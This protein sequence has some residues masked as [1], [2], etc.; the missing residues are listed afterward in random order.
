MISVKSESNKCCGCGLCSM[1]CPNHAISMKS[2]NEGFL[3]PFIQKE[4]CID[5]GLCLEYCV[6]SEKYVQIYGNNSSNIYIARIKD[7][8]ILMKSASGGMFSLLS[9]AVLKMNGCIYGAV[10]DEQQKVIH[11][12]AD[13]A[14]DRN[15][16]RGSKY[17]QSDICEMYKYITDD[18]ENGNYVLFTGTPCEVGAV[19]AFVKQKKINNEHLFLCDLICHGVCSPMIWDKYIGYVKKEIGPIKQINMRDKLYG[20]GY[21]MTILGEAGVYRKN[22]GADP[23]IRIF[24]KNYALRKSCF[25]CP[26]KKTLRVSD[27]TIGDF[28]NAPK[29]Y[30]K[31]SD[32]KGVSV[33]LINSEKGH[34]LFTDCMTEA[35]VNASTLQEAMQPNLQKQIGSSLSRDRFFEDVQT[36]SFENILKKYTEVG[37]KN[38]ILGKSKRVIKTILG[39]NKK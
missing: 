13:S 14:N 23:F 31:Y 36:H 39:R 15:K 8:N 6:F 21:N 5:C 7:K 3:F 38:R 1:I 18:L 10:F 4:S 2:D 22:G 35:E 33:V 11:I 16:M 25:K 29:H 20:D 34:R 32:K 9:D 12:R 26:Y 19:A 28:Q 17:V 24:Q 37:F 30:S 27:I